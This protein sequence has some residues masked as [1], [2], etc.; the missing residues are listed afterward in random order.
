MCTAPLDDSHHRM[1]RW[2]SPMLCITH[3]TRAGAVGSTRA[4]GRGQRTRNRRCRTGKLEC[5]MVGEL[6]HT[7]RYQTTA[8]GR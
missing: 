1:V 6:A 3:W 7:S 8:K 2:S 5:L 4:L